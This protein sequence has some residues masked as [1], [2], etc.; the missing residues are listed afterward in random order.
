LFD[1]STEVTRSLSLALA[2]ELPIIA[3]GGITSGARAR[4]KLE[5]GASLV[6]IYSGLIFSGPTLV[7]ECIEAT[8]TDR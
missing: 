8:S 7:T 2:G 4:A 1:K 5:A 3:A 6:Q